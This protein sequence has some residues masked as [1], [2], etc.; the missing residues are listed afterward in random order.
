[1]AG[2]EPLFHNNYWKLTQFEVWSCHWFAKDEIY[3][4]KFQN[5]HQLC[6]IPIEGP[7]LCFRTPPWAR[8]VVQST[9][10]ACVSFRV[11]PLYPTFP[12]SFRPP[13]GSSWPE[14]FLDLRI[15]RWSVWKDIQNKMK[16]MIWHNFILNGLSFGLSKKQLS[17]CQQCHTNYLGIS[18]TE[19][20]TIIPCT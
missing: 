19:I 20:S 7:G 16:Q 10:F 15:A 2:T 6:F 13:R 1:M 3:N 9:L 11:L 17:T 4:S 18:V 14:G 12:V 5:V 8:R